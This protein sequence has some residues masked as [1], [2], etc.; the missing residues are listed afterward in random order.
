MKTRLLFLSVSFAGFVFS[1]AQT[2]ASNRVSPMDSVQIQ[3]SDL[4]MEVIYSRPYLKGREFGKDIVP[5]GKVWRTGANEATVFE[6]SRDVM[7]EGKKLEKGKYSLYTIPDEKQ[8]VVIFNRDWNQ[9]GTV[10]NED[11]DALRVTVPT[12]ETDQPTEQFTISLDPTGD[13]CMTWGEKVFVF[14]VVCPT[15]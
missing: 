15:E 11:R 8:T 2:S 10:Y 13:V 7:V 12:I 4:D 3:F 9:W 1:N 5:Y 14:H 6:I